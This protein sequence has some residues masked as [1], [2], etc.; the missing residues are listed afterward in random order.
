MPLDLQVINN[1]GYDGAKADMCICWV[2]L[3]VLMAGYLL[4]ED[5]NLTFGV[6][7]EGEVTF[8]EHFYVYG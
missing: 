8:N 2:I 1:K 4:F 6:L 5:S 7:I 3:F